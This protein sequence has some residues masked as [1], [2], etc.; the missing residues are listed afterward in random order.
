MK[1]ICFQMSRKVWLAALLTLCFS[2]PALAQKITV[3]GTVLDPEGEPLIGASVLV[4]GET[5]GTATDIDGN[6][7]I[8]APSNGTLV[9]SYVGYDTQNIPV[10]GKTTINVNMTENTLVLGEVVAIG[11]GTVKKSDATGAVATVK[12]SEIEAGLATSAQDLLV[13][14]SP[15]VVVTTDGS[16]QGGA[17]IQIR[18]G[19]S[20]SATND[21]L[22]VIDGVPMSTK[23]VY[24][25][26]NPLSLVSPEN[27]ESMTILKDASATA[28]YGSRASNGVI[29]ITTKKGSSGRPQVTFTA[30]AYIN[31]PR[32]YLDV[33]DAD[34]FRSFILSRYGEDSAQA[35]QLGTASTDWQKEATRTTIS[36][37]YSLS[38]GGTA[39]QLP[40]R[41]SVSY[42]NNNGIIKR[43]SM[44]RVTGS[45]SVTPKFF[46]NTLSVNANVKGSYV[47]NM[48][49]DNTLGTCVTMNPT[50][51]PRDFE[52]GSPVFDYWTSY[53]A[54]GEVTGPG[55]KGQDLNTSTAP[56]NP[57]AQLMGK[58]SK[59]KSYQSIGNLQLNY[60]LPFLKELSADLNLAYDYQHGTWGGGNYANTPMAWAGGWQYPVYKA[61]GTIEKAETV[62]NGG[63]SF[64][65]QFQTRLNLLLDFVLNYNKYFDA[66]KTSVDV[67]GGYSWQKFKNK[68]RSYSYVN[69]YGYLPGTFE[70]D[71]AYEQY[72]GVQANPTNYFRSPHQLVSFFGRA[73]FV[74]L[75]KYLLTATVR[76]DGTS[77]FS[78]D[79]RWGTFP[80]FAIGWKILEEDFMEGARGW[81]NELKIRGGY[82]VTGQQD[83]GDDYFPYLPVY[84]VWTGLGSIYPALLPGGNAVFPVSPEGYNADIKWEETHTWNGGIDFG[85]LNNRIM[86]SFEIYRRKTKDLLFNTSYPA[87]SNITNKG[88]MNIGD[89]VNKGIEFNITARP[90]VTPE[91]TWT[92]SYNIGYN[93]NEITKL[94]DGADTSFGGVGTD[95]LAQKHAMG[96]PASSFYVYEQVYDQDGN[97]LEGV[98]VDRNG[99][100]RINE[101]DKYF[102]HCPTPK[103]T[104]TWN[105]TIN[106]RSWDFGIVFRANIGNWLYNSNMAGTTDMASN[107]ALPLSN[108]MND[109]FLFENQSSLTKLSDYFVQNASF[110]RCDNITLGY[111]WSNLF[112]DNLR[113][114]LYGAVQN[115]FVI[116]KYKGMDPESAGGID[117]GV[118]PRP[119]TFSVGVVA[120]F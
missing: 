102:Y 82:G 111:T 71:P 112:Q 97:P 77:R 44:D 62:K 95:L 9:F 52:N 12:P 83:I 50:I 68:G 8:Q 23:G 70:H 84:S 113:L 56:V 47:V 17:S 89:L 2:F 100:G 57:I 58:Y 15:G 87:G 96:H 55:A 39:G 103:V 22:I 73:N 32:K 91:L 5:M 63:T 118:Y 45:V 60:K 6:Y 92:T 59:G 30:N 24:G 115:P 61:D 67:T 116:T 86:G 109:T 99:D 33:M 117:S 79:H 31:T 69:N 88:N 18:G 78:K 35:A 37:D 46:N 120:Q 20:I 29:I 21:P 66:I 101:A 74:F 19:A 98:F 53:N 51:L 40:Y 10:A 110:V 3:S 90:V 94:S 4:Q 42:T 75:D 36:S 80:A 49:S 65:D 119:I 54:A 1:D 76:R 16:P 13:G 28:I 26:S 81:M 34:Q 38:V 7:T 72:L 104:M 93:K 14:A 105:N 64:E 43:S 25:A 114:R 27:V 106:W 107:N 11:Y 48:Y 85:F 108:M 41:V